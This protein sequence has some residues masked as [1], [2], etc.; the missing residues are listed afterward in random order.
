MELLKIV[1]KYYEEGK[2]EKALRAISKNYSSSKDMPDEILELAALSL[3][4]FEDYQGATELAIIL[5]NRKNQKGLELLAQITAYANKD[6]DLLSSIYQ[7]LPNNIAVCNAY[8]IRARD[9]DSN[10]RVGYVIDAAIQHM[11]DNEVAS[12]HLLNNAA[13]LLLAKGDDKGDMA[14]AVWFWEIALLK[15][16]KKNY[17]HR[18]A[19]YFWLSKAY[20]RLGKN[21]LA[22][23]SA[24]KSLVL[25][26]KQISLDPINQK[27]QDNFVGA[28][29]RLEELTC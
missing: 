27:F 2:F 1:R 20:E 25:W 4:R 5:A 11:N 14:V 21:S 17:H 18:A 6:D 24:K 13:R 10:I 7:K 26:V 12:I 28:E 19:V 23:A 15:Y 9:A 8:A 22:I 3:F 29:K 16:G